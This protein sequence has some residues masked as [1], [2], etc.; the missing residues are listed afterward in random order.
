MYKDLEVSDPIHTTDLRVSTRVLTL[1]LIAQLTLRPIHCTIWHLDRFGPNTHHHQ[2]F[3]HLTQPRT[4][5]DLT[6][7]FPLRVF[8][9]T[10]E[11]FSNRRTARPNHAIDIDGVGLLGPH[12]CFAT[13]DKVLFVFRYTRVWVVGINESPVVEGGAVVVVGP[14]VCRR[15]GVKIK[16][17]AFAAIQ[18]LEDVSYCSVL[19]NY[20]NLNRYDCL[21]IRM[22]SIP[23]SCSFR[24]MPYDLC[25]QFVQ[26]PRHFA[27]FAQP[28]LYP[29][30]GSSPVASLPTPQALSQRL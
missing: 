6:P 2:A 1:P 23:S 10:P 28:R 29:K 16:P 8:R 26:Q 17:L 30:L 9:T 24:P 3:S 27:N 11:D 25:R 22:R 19:E 21:G 7:V 14:G 18:V 4:R 5:F 13:N 15:R 20:P 12:V